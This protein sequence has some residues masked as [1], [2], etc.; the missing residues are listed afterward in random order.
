MAPERNIE[1]DTNQSTLITTDKNIIV[2]AD[3]VNPQDGETI[4]AYPEPVAKLFTFGEPEADAIENWPN[5]LATGI[6]VE[7]IPDLLRMVADPAL[8]GSDLSEEDDPKYWAPVHAWR[9]L[10]QLQDASVVEPLLQQTENLFDYETGF[11]DWAIDGLPDVYAEIG[12]AAIP[13]LNK[14]I[15]D[16]A[17]PADARIQAMTGLTKIALKYPEHREET[18]TFFVQQLEQVAQ[19]DPEINAYLI[20]KLVDLKAVE[21]LPLIQQA[22]SDDNVDQSLI[23][24]EDV[25][26]GFGLKERRIPDFTSPSQNFGRSQATHTNEGHTHTHT[27]QHSPST[28]SVSPPKGNKNKVTKKAKAKM[29]KKSRKNNRDK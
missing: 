20:T 28:R 9:A 11:G 25:E 3:P 17:W 19:N 18:I 26:V 13:I 23:D 1:V 2:D 10:G 7:H 4:H 22:F 16:P 14:C 29:E 21:T 6:T 12:A 8:R 5:Y 27:H 15:V 24:L